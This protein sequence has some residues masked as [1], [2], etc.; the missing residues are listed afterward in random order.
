MVGSAALHLQPLL[1]RL[2]VIKNNE[3]AQERTGEGE[4]GETAQQVKVPAPMFGNL[5]L[6]PGMHMV[7]GRN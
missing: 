5:S 4:V 3:E 7:E 6:I 1:I 2:N